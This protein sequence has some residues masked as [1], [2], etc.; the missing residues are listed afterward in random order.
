MI[1]LRFSRIKEEWEVSKSQAKVGDI[2]LTNELIV[3]PDNWNKVDKIK[4]EAIGIVCIPASHMKDGKLRMVSLDYMD[5]N[6]PE[7]GSSTN[8]SM[9]WGAGGGI[10]GVPYLNKGPYINTSSALTTEIQ[11]VNGN[12]YI[13]SDDGI[14]IESLTTG[15]GYKNNINNKLA[16]CPFLEDGSQNPLFIA[17]EYTVPG[18]STISKIKNFLADFNGE[19]NTQQIMKQVTVVTPE[20]NQNTGNYASAHCCTLY[21]KGGNI[22]YLPASGELAYIVVSQNKIN[23][24]RQIIGL[25]ALNL[26][27]C[28]SSS[29]SNSEYSMSVNFSTN[30]F[31]YNRR[32]LQ[33]SVLAVSAF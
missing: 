28:W 32:G 17:T 11:G 1:S 7:I 22:W 18:I 9:A 12:I 23:Q 27:I 30:G 4:Y 26:T 13:P 16:P 20:N 5:Y 24:S 10:E 31:S 25:N 33:S 21:N 19:Y 2:V 8:V 29:L 14:V 15:Y 6:N 3:S